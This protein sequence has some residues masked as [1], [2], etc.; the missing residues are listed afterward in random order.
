MKELPPLKLEKARFVTAL[1]PLDET[2]WSEH[3]A[4]RVRF[5]VATNPGAALGPLAKILSG[6]ELARFM[7]AIKV[8][9][10]KAMPVRDPG[11]RRGR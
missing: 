6:G 4:E 2:E 7:L 1:T 8:V 5:E 9:L 10:A 11:L 3:G